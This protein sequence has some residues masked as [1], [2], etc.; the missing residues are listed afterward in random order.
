MFAKATAPTVRS[1]AALIVVAQEFR[2]APATLDVTAGQKVTFELENKDTVDHNVVSPEG[3][4]REVI[5]GGSQK[6]SVEWTAPSR[7]GTFKFVCTYHR[8]MEMTVNVK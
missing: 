2:F 3:A 5:L 1:S 7:V 4:F 6:K 8:G